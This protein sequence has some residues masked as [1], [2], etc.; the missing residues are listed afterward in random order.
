MAVV[1][2]LVNKA[3]F[4]IKWSSI[5]IDL[6]KQQAK[7]L[8]FWWWRR[9]VPETWGHYIFSFYMFMNL[10]IFLKIRT[11]FCRLIDNTTVAL[12]LVLVPADKK[13]TN[14]FP[15]EVRRG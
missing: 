14:L 7:L 13:I 12:N 10:N 2:G 3:E 5:P 15:Y 1:K 4:M 9:E 11:Y 8:I 6:N